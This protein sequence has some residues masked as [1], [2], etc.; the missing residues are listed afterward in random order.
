MV[1][2]GVPRRWIARRGER[3]RSRTAVRRGAA[4]AA[5]VALVGIALLGLSTIAVAAAPH[6]AGAVTIGVS[7][8]RMQAAVTAA[9]WPQQRGNWCGVASIAAVASYV[10]GSVN[11]A[12]VAGFLNSSAAVSIWGT[13][14]PAYGGAGFQANIS[15]D[16]GTDPRAIARGQGGMDGGIYHNIVDSW[17]AWDATWHLA[18]DLR[19]YQQPLTV[20]VDGG[21]HSVVISQI[22]ATG[23]P[24]AD[25]SS[26]TGIE[27]W[28]PGVGA[29]AQIQANQHEIV[30]IWDW[31]NDYVYW[32]SRYDDSLDPD[33][34]VGVYAGEHLWTGNWV[35]IRPWGLPNGGADWSLNQWGAPIPG[36]HGEYPPGYTPPTPTPTLTP[37]ATPTP[38][39]IRHARAAPTAAATAAARSAIALT[40]ATVTTEASG[41]TIPLAPD[42][43]ETPSPAGGWCAGPYCLAGADL[44]WWGASLGCVLL[45][46][47]LWGAIFTRARRADGQPA[48]GPPEGG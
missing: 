39:P 8:A 14:P 22:I 1:G 27:V 21:Q 18:V 44:P 11:Q 17:G 41:R 28:D 23:D 25:Q 4:L 30:P 34:S 10:S 19:D 13:P 9:A 5:L 43:A 26:I 36:L 16:T 42:A 12:S 24:I 40:G 46:A 48:T 2:G 29:N 7:D 38:L 20:I 37:T 33:P 45:L 47:G 31:Y 32:G 6:S 35:Y 15:L 3:A